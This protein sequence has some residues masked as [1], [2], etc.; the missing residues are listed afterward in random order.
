MKAKKSF[1]DFIKALLVIVLILITFV[2]CRA[3]FEEKNGS[4]GNVG[5]TVNG[6][7]TVTET[8]TEIETETESVPEGCVEHEFIYY[9]DLGFH[10]CKCGATDTTEHTYKDCFNNTHYQYCDLCGTYA[11]DHVYSFTINPDGTHTGKACA[12]CEYE[13]EEWTEEHEFI[14]DADANQYWCPCGYVVDGFNVDWPGVEI[15]GPQDIT[16]YTSGMGDWGIRVEDGVVYRHTSGASVPMVGPNFG[17]VITNGIKIHGGRYLVFKIRCDIPL[18]NLQFA[19]EQASDKVLFTM[20]SDGWT[21]FVFDMNAVNKDFYCPDIDGNYP[22]M[23]KYI[24]FNGVLYNS[25]GMDYTQYYFDFAYFAVCEDAIGVLEV[26][27]EDQLQVYTADNTFTTMT[28][29][30]FSSTHI[31]MNEVETE[32]ETEAETEIESESETE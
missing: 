16:P 21:T 24:V 32:S 28:K 29:D 13:E 25:S 18:D 5:G 26:T 14:Y 10:V 9:H 3:F 17:A 12:Y 23:G 19:F 2:A 11:E 30:E 31:F 4:G 20:S 27:G 7:G 22:N 8:E 15:L 6:G 1:I